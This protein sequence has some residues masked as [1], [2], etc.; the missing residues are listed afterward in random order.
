MPPPTTWSANISVA[1]NHKDS[2]DEQDMM[3]EATAAYFIPL[4]LS[5]LHYPSCRS[6]ISLLNSGGFDDSPG[7]D[8]G[9]FPARNYPV[10]S[11]RRHPGLWPAFPLIFPA[12][13]H[14]NERRRQS[15]PQPLMAQRHL[16]TTPL[17]AASG[18]SYQHRLFRGPPNAPPF[19]E[20]TP[21]VDSRAGPWNFAPKFTR[22]CFYLTQLDAGLPGSDVY[23][24]PPWP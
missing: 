8:S 1:V 6:C 11:P 3:T 20:C 19:G 2:Q 7:R 10:I 12:F 13:P 22:I 14:Q 15:H 5:R 9:R 24:E 18:P 21:P 17:S 4:T 16:T 23:G